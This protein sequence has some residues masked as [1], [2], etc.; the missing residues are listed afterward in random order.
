MKIFL[1]H[2]KAATDEQIEAWK[3][4]IIANLPGEEV[5]VIPGRDDFNAN[6]AS[7][8]TFDAWARGVTDRRDN[9]TGERVYGA[10]FVPGYTVGKATALIVGSALH[11]GVP[12]VVIDTTDCGSTEFRRGTQLVVEDADDYVNGWWIDT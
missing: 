11:H 4:A 5:E 6:I 10:V 12:V 7:D 1:A 3:K 8:G 2:S 9:F